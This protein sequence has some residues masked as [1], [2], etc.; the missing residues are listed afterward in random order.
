[1]ADDIVSVISAAWVAGLC[2]K[3]SITYDSLQPVWMTGYGIV[4]QY[5]QAGYKPETIN[6]PF[7]VDH[8]TTYIVG[9]TTAQ[10]NNLIGHLIY[11][12]DNTTTTVYTGNTTYSRFYLDVETVRV[13]D[14]LDDTHPCNTN[15]RVAV[16]ET[17]C[18][19]LYHDKNRLFVQ[20]YAQE[21]G[22]KQQ[23]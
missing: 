8:Y 20:P 18:V 22:G 6:A 21:F 11:L 17:W 3:G 13:L 1:M 23:Q 2:T 5:T 7:G 19:K 15:W 12:Y 10:I 16:A 4:Y 9:Q 14:K